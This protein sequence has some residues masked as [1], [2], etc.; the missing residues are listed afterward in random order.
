MIGCLM[1]LLLITCLLFGG[2]ALKPSLAADL[3]ESRSGSLVGLTTGMTMGGINIPLALFAL[4]LGWELFRFGWRWADG[5]AVRATASGLVP[6]GSTLL[7]PIAWHDIGDLSYALV[8]RAPS[9]VIK[10]RNGSTRTIRGIDNDNGAA[11]QFAAYA[12]QLSGGG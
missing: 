5:I 9:L 2:A 3:A 12:R 10:L 11:E 7:K 1:P 8:G 6:H 4:Y